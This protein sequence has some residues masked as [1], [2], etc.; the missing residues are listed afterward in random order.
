M[1]RNLDGK[2]QYQ[3]RH[4]YY[5][6]TAVVGDVLYCWGGNQEGL[7]KSH[8]SPTKRECTSVIDAFN[9]LS[10]AWSSQP[11]SG[12]PPLGIIGVS[13]TPISNN[14]YYFGGWCGHDGCFHNSLN[15]LDTCTLQWKELQPTGDNSVTKRAYGG[16][17]A[18]GTGSGSEGEPQQLLVIGGQGTATQHHPQF[19]YDYGA[20]ITNEQSIYNLFSGQWIVPFVSGQ[21]FPPAEEFII[22]KIS[23]NKG[24]MHG[25]LVNDGSYCSTDSI[26]LFQLSHNTINW[27][28]LKPGS[29]PND[30]LWPDARNRH[31]STIINGVST[32]PTLVMIGGVDSDEQLV[33]ECW[34]LETK[35][36]S[37]IKVLMFIVCYCECELSMTGD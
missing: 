6:T 27:E 25:G 18:I 4:K 36:Y 35:Q 30:G 14:I 22:Q 20:A 13:C 15:C 19:K 1:D 32:S 16:M 33:N 37:W 24:I 17:I 7:D 34:L 10:G 28:C 26:Y 29:V 8:D 9:L 5:H 2:V 11:T 21:C 23:Y 12:T 3:L 31:A